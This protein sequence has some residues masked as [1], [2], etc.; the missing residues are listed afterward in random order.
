MEMGL[1]MY[2]GKDIVGNC[3]HKTGAQKVAAISQGMHGAAA[4]QRVQKY[5]LI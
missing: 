2:R 1:C 5:I 3:R 4:A